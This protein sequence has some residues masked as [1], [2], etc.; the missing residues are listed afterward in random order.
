MTVGLFGLAARIMEVNCFLLVEVGRLRRTII[1]IVDPLHRV[2]YGH[3]IERGRHT[4]IF[5]ASPVLP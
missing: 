4:K 1:T 3:L 5:I 2:D